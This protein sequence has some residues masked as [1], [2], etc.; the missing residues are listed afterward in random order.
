MTQLLINLRQNLRELFKSPRTWEIVGYTTVLLVI[1]L[2]HSYNLFNFPYYENDEGTYISQGWAIIEL[3]KLAPYTY[4]YDHAPLGWLVIAFF[5]KLVGG[6]YAFGTAIDTIRVMILLMHISSSFF[7]IRIVKKITGST[8]SGFIAAL[9]FSILPIANY[10]Q[11]RVLLDNILVFWTLPAFYILL[12]KK[13]K[14]RTL[15]LSAV[16]LAFALLSKESGAV[17]VPAFIFLIF[18]GLDK[19]Q[20]IFGLITWSGFFGGILA[21]YIQLAILKTELFPSSDKVSLIGTLGFQVSRG[22]ATAFWQEGSDFMRTFTAWVLRDTLSVYIL[23]SIIALSIIVYLFK[24]TNRQ[25]TAAM[26][27]LVCY[28]YFL[29]RGKLVLEFY[30]IPLFPLVSIMLGLMFSLLFKYFNQMTRN[31]VT[32]VVIT[33]LLFLQLIV[34]PTVFTKDETTQYKNTISWIRENIPTDKTLVIDCGVW[35]ELRDSKDG[36]EK[37]YE[38]ADWYWKSD[39]DPDVRVKKLKDNPENI[40][41]IFATF[42]YYVDM[43]SGALPFNSKALNESKQIKD[44]S[45]KG[46]TATM[47]Q[48]V[49]DK[50]QILKNTWQNY[51][52]TFLVDNSY[53]FNPLAKK[54]TSEGQGYALLRSLWSDDM[55]TFDSIWNWTKTNLQIRPNDKLIAWNRNFDGTIDT[56]N[57]TDGDLDI[58]LALTLASKKLKSTNPVQSEIY[59]EQALS[60]VKDIWKNRVVT[61]GDKVAL[62]PF[63]SKASLGYE[64][65][66]PSYFSPAHYRIFAEL[67]KENPWS[68]LAFD[69]YGIFEIIGKNRELIPNWTKFNY[70][71]NIWEDATEVTGNKFANDFG[72]DALRAYFRASLDKTWFNRGEADKFLAKGGTFFEKEFKANGIVKSSYKP[73]GDVVEDYESTAMDAAVH[74]TLSFT[75]SKETGSFWRQKFIERIDLEQKL[76]DAKNNYYNQNWGWFEFARKEKLLKINFD[77]KNNNEN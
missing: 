44:F 66:N 14:I 4:W 46:I 69:S 18:T 77:E 73:N 70:V 71:T 72:N 63:A 6:F 62:L 55:E 53:V 5:S 30:L 15:I 16:L 38:N 23:I 54:T 26:L 56:E 24:F 20:K 37:V 42:Q 2:T 59:K 65:I 34:N 21:L 3:N 43:A 39:L 19:S 12:D 10:F 74:S 76:F 33:V 31:V 52:K 9:F 13:L 51:K 49:K 29:L 35:M 11:R 7:I 27:L 68:N 45:D 60:L 22:N 58:A 41:Y 50:P 1:F 8:L 48:L 57:A 17:F 28:L 75:Q 25:W 36:K 61:V 67:D 40:D 47:F 32:G 64:I